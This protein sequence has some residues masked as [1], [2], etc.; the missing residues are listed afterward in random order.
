M[1]KIAGYYGEQSVADVTITSIFVQIKY[2]ARLLY[3]Y[4]VQL[5]FDNPFMPSETLF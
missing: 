1:N 5:T 4:S 2:S 3:L